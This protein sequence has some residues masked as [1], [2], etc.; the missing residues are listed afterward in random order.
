MGNFLRL[1]TKPVEVAVDNTDEFPERNRIQAQFLTDSFCF[2][3]AKAAGLVDETTHKKGEVIKVTENATRPSYAPEG[4][5][6]HI[7][8]NSLRG[9]PITDDT[10]LYRE[11]TTHVGYIACCRL[12]EHNGR[13]VVYSIYRRTA[14]EKRLTTRAGDDVK[15]CINEEE[16]C[17]LSVD[18][19]PILGDDYPMV[20][21]SMRAANTNGW[22][23]HNVLYCE[24]IVSKHLTPEQITAMF[25]ES[26]IT[27]VTKAMLV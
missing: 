4:D 1:R 22:M 16:H 13:D 7:D 10:Q 3:V 27:L 26:G 25:K 23:A 17:T 19:K 11:L 20:I 2:S 6:V 14:T 9:R 12:F 18:I 5:I 21:R 15:N 8:V 24:D